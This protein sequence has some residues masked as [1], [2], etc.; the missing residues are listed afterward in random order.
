VRHVV[1]T[2][3]QCVSGGVSVY[4]PTLL[5]YEVHWVYIL[6]IVQGG[7]HIHG[8]VSARYAVHTHSALLTGRRCPMSTCCVYCTCLLCS[9]YAPAALEGFN[10]AS[11]AYSHGYT[12]PIYSAARIH[13]YSTMYV[14]AALEECL[15]SAVQVGLGGRGRGDGAAQLNT[16]AP[17]PPCKMHGAWVWRILQGRVCGS[18]VR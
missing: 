6:R 9:V 17:L 8:P 10:S 14:P 16:T 1:C 11:G 4:T 13:V 5:P 18:G 2:S 15:E 7:V 3:I 12:V